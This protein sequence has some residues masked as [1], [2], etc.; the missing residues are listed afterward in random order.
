VSVAQVV[1]PR[2]SRQR[3]R[4]ADPPQLRPLSS[5]RSPE[6]L[7]RRLDERDERIARMIFSRPRRCALLERALTQTEGAMSAIAVDS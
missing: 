1:R 2:T 5:L 6:D 3:R 7:V 4:V